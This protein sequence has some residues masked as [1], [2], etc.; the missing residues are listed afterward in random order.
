[1]SAYEPS[2]Q[3]CDADNQ[4][5]HRWDEYFELGHE[6]VSRSPRYAALPSPESQAC[7][8]EGLAGISSRPE[9]SSTGAIPRYSTRLVVRK[10][11]AVSMVPATPTI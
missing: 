5:H 1:M 3:V 4:D 10:S 11:S 6:H 9:G 8:V 7:S 2:A